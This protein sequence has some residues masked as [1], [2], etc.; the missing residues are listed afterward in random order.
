MLDQIVNTML[1]TV[2]L[3]DRLNIIDS[4]IFILDT[5]F[6]DEISLTELLAYLK[7]QIA[8]HRPKILIARDRNCHL[9]DI[10]KM[11]RHNLDYPLITELIR[12]KDFKY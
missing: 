6:P 9:V 12:C 11:I 4:D 2:T 8:L 1:D 10:F 5:P 3:N 7:E